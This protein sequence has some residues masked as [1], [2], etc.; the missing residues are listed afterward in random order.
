MSKKHNSVTIEEVKAA[1][2]KKDFT[3]LQDGRTTICL[4]TLDNGFT[5]R[6]ESSCVDKRN[7][8]QEMGEKISYENALDQVWMLLGFRLAERLHQAKLSKGRGARYRDAKSGMYV[9][10]KYAKLNPDTTVKEQ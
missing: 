1:V 7:F 2:R 3:V 9:T 6:G 4:L 5:V 8:D 10:A